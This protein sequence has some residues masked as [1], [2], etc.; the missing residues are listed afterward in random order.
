MFLT[1]GNAD[2]ALVVLNR[3]QWAW[4][5]QWLASSTWICRNSSQLSRVRAPPPAPWLDGGLEPEI[6]LLWTGYLQKPNQACP[7]KSPE[8]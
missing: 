6:T 3:Q 2:K 8:L 4:V 5:S 1:W 7:A